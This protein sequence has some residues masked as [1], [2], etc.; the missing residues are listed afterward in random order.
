MSRLTS[1]PLIGSRLTSSQL[2]GTTSLDLLDPIEIL[3][4]TAGSFVGGTANVSLT[5]SRAGTVYVVATTQNTMP[6]PAQV[7]AGQDHTSVTGVASASFQAESGANTDSVELDITAVGTYYF[8][9]TAQDTGGNLAAVISLGSAAIA[10][11][12]YTTLIADKGA[13]WTRSGSMG[14]PSNP[15]IIIAGELL[16]TPDAASFHTLLT[17]NSVVDFEFIYTDS[18]GQFRGG[19]T[20]DFGGRATIVPS[21]GPQM[22]RF[23]MAVDLS[24]ATF[25]AGVQLYVDGVATELTSQTWGQNLI[26]DFDAAGVFSILESDNQRGRIFNGAINF[27]YFDRPSSVIDFSQASNRNRFD[28][29]EIGANGSGVTGSQPLFYMTGDRDAWQSGSNL[30]SLSGF[31]VNGSFL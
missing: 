15:R 19:V 4:H 13:Y 27:L 6:S 1:S 31:T 21:T 24:A 9:L 20:S 2:L 8:W 7:V 22:S 3:D 12:A 17:W 30:G 14:N 5:L 28:A 26:P 16:R 23:I 18:N 29:T 11:N 10:A 25:A